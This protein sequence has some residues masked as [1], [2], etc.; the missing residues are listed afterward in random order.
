MRKF[1]IS[2]NSGRLAGKVD[3]FDEDGRLA[4]QAQV[5]F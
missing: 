1:E 5:L 4:Y 2:Q 3:I